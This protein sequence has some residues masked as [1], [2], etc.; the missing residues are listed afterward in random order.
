M[1][2]ATLD[3]GGHRLSDGAT[4]TVMTAVGVRARFAVTEWVDGERWAWDVL[5]LPATSHTVRA[6]TEDR[7]E[8]AFEVPWFAA[9]YLAVCSIALGRIAELAAQVPS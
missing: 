9:P 8:A 5:G 1:R 3:G 4:G 2:S 6:L 7:C